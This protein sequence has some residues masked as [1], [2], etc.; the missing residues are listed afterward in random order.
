VSEVHFWIFNSIPFIYVTVIEPVSCRF[1]SQ[2]SVV[3]LEVQDADSPR[4]SFIVENNFHSP[5]FFA[6]PGEFEN[7]SV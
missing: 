1:L 6:I 2:F 7:Y 4:S 5:G 3:Q